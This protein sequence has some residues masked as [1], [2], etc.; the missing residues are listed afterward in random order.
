MHMASKMGMSNAKILGD[1]SFS[2]EQIQQSLLFA[3]EQ[4]KSDSL[5]WTKRKGSDAAKQQN[6]RPKIDSQMRVRKQAKD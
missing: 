2:A 4:V 6:K 1:S 5:N 3:R